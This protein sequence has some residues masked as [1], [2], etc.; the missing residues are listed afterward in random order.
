MQGND[1]EDLVL[2]ATSR[3]TV[4]CNLI[5]SEVYKS[6]FNWSYG[7]AECETMFFVR[8]ITKIPHFSGIFSKMPPP[9]FKN[10]TPGKL[11]PEAG[12]ISPRTAFQA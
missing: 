9:Y 3:F 8:Q 1:L 6:F 7:V 2:L 11:R 4:E 10:T 5:G 12:R